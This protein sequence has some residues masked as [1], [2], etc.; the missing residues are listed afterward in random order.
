MAKIVPPLYPF[1]RKLQAYDRQKKRKALGVDLYLQFIEVIGKGYGLQSKEELFWIC[2]MLWQKPYHRPSE[3]RQLFDNYFLDLQKKEE[4]G[5][6]V[7]P[8][9]E[10][11]NEENRTNIEKPE[12]DSPGKPDS[13]PEE[14]PGKKEENEIKSSVETQESSPVKKSVALKFQYAARQSSRY[15]KT[16]LDQIE[17]EVLSKAFLVKGKYTSISPRKAAESIRSLRIEH[18]S[19]DKRFIDVAATINRV[20]QKGF[21]DQVILK[22]GKI[23]GNKLCILIDYGGSMAAFDYLTELFEKAVKKQY[24]QNEKL[25]FYTL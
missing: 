3:F 10:D 18:I 14:D 23:A 11:L 7:K 5:T 20:A 6:P 8:Q 15:L 1:F 2:K 12:V 19:P 13:D 21:L 16:D 22:G 24:P 4:A 17:K 9:D 25:L